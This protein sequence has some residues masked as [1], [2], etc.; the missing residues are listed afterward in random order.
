M[1]IAEAY[2]CQVDAPT[3]EIGFYFTDN[4]IVI[5]ALIRSYQHMGEE[6]VSNENPHFLLLHPLPLGWPSGLQSNAGGLS[7]PAG[8]QRMPQ[9]HLDHPIQ[10]AHNDPRE[11]RW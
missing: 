5:Y 8:C 10:S 1:N 3:L 4:G 6:E 9:N 7:F 11:M 2:W